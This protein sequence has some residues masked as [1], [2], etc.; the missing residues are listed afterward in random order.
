MNLRD[1]REQY[2]E[3]YLKIRNCNYIIQSSDVEFIFSTLEP[4]EFD[5]FKKIMYS[6]DKEKIKQYI[7]HRKR[8]T[9][10][11]DKM[12]IRQLRTVGKNLRIENYHV[13]SK[14]L[15]LKEIDNV[16]KRLKKSFERVSI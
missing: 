6:F 16:V 4:D 14:D 9:Y 15:L 11:F 2:H 10:L 13:L 12:S 3:E 1:F 5:T 8:K 7:E